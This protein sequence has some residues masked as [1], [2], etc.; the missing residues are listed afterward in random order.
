M[1]RHVTAK[2][3]GDIAIPCTPWPSDRLDLGRREARPGFV[4]GILFLE[5]N[6]LR[7][8]ANEE[9]ATRAVMRLAAG[10]LDETGFTA[11]L[12]ENVVRE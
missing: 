6:G 7:F 9:A 10:T 8:A 5:L 3:S 2:S 11:F 4:A 1:K 12:R